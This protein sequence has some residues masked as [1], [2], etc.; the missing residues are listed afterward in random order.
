MNEAAENKQLN[1]L[2]WYKLQRGEL[3]SRLPPGAW[4]ELGVHVPAWELLCSST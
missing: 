1:G 2:S 3:R 4:G